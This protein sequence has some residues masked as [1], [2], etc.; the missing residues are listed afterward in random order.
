M[1]V[2]FGA[3]FRNGLEDV[4][5][6]YEALARR[7]REVSSGKRIEVASD[8]PAATVRAMAERNEMAVLDY[9]KQTTDTVESRLTVVDTVLSDVLNQLTAA[10]VKAAAGRNT[11]LNQT[12]RDALAGEIRGSA[13]AILTAVSTSY[14]GMFLFSGG[15][16][17]TP[18]FAPGPPVSP[19]QG[20]ARVQSLDVARGRAVQVTFD[21]GAIL[22]G[23]AAAD[24]FQVLETLAADVQSGNMTGID[25]GL[26]EL[27]Q[28]FERVTTAQTGVGIDLARL[29]DDRSRLNKLHES[30]NQRRSQAEDANLAE[31]ISGMTQA[32]AAHQAALGAL[33]RAGR[34]SLMDYLR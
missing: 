10:Q 6:A 13:S 7:Q 29:T 12:Q 1:R 26:V 20:D 8:D 22:Q 4:N 27:R 16:A 24:V 30:A 9:Y 14:R 19:Y 31:A 25:A 3:I 28:A 17:N 21:G 34:L 2:T 11:F 15:Q 18:P 5:R 32:D 33:A 23:S